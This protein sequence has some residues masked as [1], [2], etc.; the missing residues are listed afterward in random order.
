MTPKFRSIRKI[1]F[2]NIFYFI[3]LSVFVVIAYAQDT[4]P[5]LK[6]RN[7]QLVAAWNLYPEHEACASRQFVGTVSKV[8]N[9]GEWVELTVR[10]KNGVKSMSLQFSNRADM[11]FILPFLKKKGKTIRFGA[12]EC[13]S[14]AF[15][16]VDS[17]R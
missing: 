13:G 17:I 8:E 5:K 10:T 3:C 9:T 1:I 2:T 4:N 15:L 12:Y 14:G 16:Y 6:I 11:S 7:N